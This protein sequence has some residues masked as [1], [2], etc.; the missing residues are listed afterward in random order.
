MKYY[1]TIV[2]VLI[3]LCF[4]TSSSLYAAPANIGLRVNAMFHKIKVVRFTLLNDSNSPMELK[5]GDDI[6]RLE[7]GKSVNVKLPVGA[8]VLLNSETQLH[9]PGDTVAEVSGYLD[10][11][12]VHLK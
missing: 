1:S 5:V 11:A 7:A 9:H 3:T 10:G 2:V 6:V 12:I 8:R 4:V